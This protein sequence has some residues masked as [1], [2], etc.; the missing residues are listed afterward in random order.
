M[1]CIIVLDNSKIPVS[2][3]MNKLYSPQ[4]G[5][6]IKVIIKNVI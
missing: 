6:K 4:Y 3:Y 2:P 5:V 1:K